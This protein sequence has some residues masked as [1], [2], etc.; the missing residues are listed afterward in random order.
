M[1]VWDF[2]DSWKILETEFCEYNSKYN[3]ILNAHS[4]PRPIHSIWK[5]FNG[6]KKSCWCITN[7]WMHASRKKNETKWNEKF[8]GEKITTSSSSS[9]ALKRIFQKNNLIFLLFDQLFDF[10][11]DFFRRQLSFSPSPPRLI[12]SKTRATVVGLSAL[13]CRYDAFIQYM[14]HFVSRT[15]DV[16]FKKLFHRRIIVQFQRC[17]IITI[18]IQCCND[19]VK[20]LVS[21]SRKRMNVLF[22]YFF[23]L[24]QTMTTTK[25]NKTND[26]DVDDDQCVFDVYVNFYVDTNDLIV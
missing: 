19:N 8:A 21:F 16:D 6:E 17:L 11:H 5:K 24:R 2:W 18:R 7:E 26:D 3:V 12:K 22:R 4:I 13:L 20:K 14:H 10:F 25:K 9:R 23:S 15:I 1:T